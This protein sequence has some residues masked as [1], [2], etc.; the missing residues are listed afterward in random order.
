[1]LANARLIGDPAQDDPPVQYAQSVTPP[2]YIIF[3][4]AV[5]SN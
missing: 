2:T 1:L 4:Q 3:T 5:R